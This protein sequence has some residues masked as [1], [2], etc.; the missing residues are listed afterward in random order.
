MSMM[1]FFRNNIKAIF[2][3]L[4]LCLIVGLF[5][6][7]GSYIFM[8]KKNIILSINGKK[9]NLE[10]FQK[11]KNNYIYQ[12]KQENPNEE[13]DEKKVEQEIIN[14]L[15]QESIFLQKAEA[16]GEVV[17]NREIMELV[18]RY[19]IF[20]K[21]ERFDIN[22]YYETVRFVLKQSPDKFE[23]TLAEKI[24]TDK[25]KL[26]IINFTKISEKELEFEYDLFKFKNQN[27]IENKKDL[28]IS[29]K[30]FESNFLNDKKTRHL[31]DWFAMNLNKSD[32]KI[33]LP[34]S[35]E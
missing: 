6:G 14:M 29:I 35:L 1:K 11:L 21:N 30:D 18:M 31:N 5:A 22:T 27:N 19:P 2:I 13:I 3:I 15:V 24:K 33:T 20:Q 26:D 32:I 17:S 16:I 28:E 34:E 25:I 4:I 8:E 23:K 9:I 7:I 12:L 10:T